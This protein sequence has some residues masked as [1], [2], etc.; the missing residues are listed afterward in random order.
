MFATVLRHLH[1]I[2][3]GAAVAALAAIATFVGGLDLTEISSDPIALAVL[4]A[5]VAAISRALG[6]LIARLRPPAA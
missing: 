6:A 4:S 5:V 3:V 1:A 2:A